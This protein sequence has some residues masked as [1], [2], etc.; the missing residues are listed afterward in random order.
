MVTHCLDGAKMYLH[1]H[2]IAVLNG[3][4]L[5]LNSCGYKTQTT[6]NRLNGALLGLMTISQKRG[7]WFIDDIEFYDG[8]TI[9]LDIKQVV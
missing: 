9:D 8:I 7:K 2:L 1:G 5:T 6:K 3:S 4:E